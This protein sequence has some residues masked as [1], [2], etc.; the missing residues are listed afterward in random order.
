MGMNIGRCLLAA[1]LLAGAGAAAARNDRM[2]LQIGQAMNAQAGR[3]MEPNLPVHF[4]SATATGAD[5]ALGTV[6]VRG[7]AD[8]YGTVNTN[9]GGAR[10][11]RSDEATCIDAFRKAVF[12]LQQRARRLGATAVVG[13][14]SNYKDGVLDSREVFECRIGHSRGFVDLK[15]GFARTGAAAPSG[16]V[17]APPAPPVR[18][19]L[20][21]VDAVPHL[22][23][24]G[25][26]EYRNFLTWS[27]PRAFA[28]APNGYFYATSGNV[29]RDGSGIIDPIARALAGCERNAKVQCK[30]YAVN[31]SVVWN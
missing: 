31:G 11:R 8:P 3:Q 14:V 12:E 20:E 6:E 22:S 29:D 28:L 7:V 23:E 24:R 30:L 9:A 10:Q 26:A 18:A 1:A 16:A 5:P 13:V 21:D 19:A 27:L 2:L 15:A 17:V 25:K 4:G